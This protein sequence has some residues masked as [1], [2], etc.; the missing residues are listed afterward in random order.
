VKPLFT[1]GIR[2]FA[3]CRT[4]YRVFFLEHSAKQPLPRAALGKVLL[5]VMNWFTECRTLGTKKL[6]AKTCEWQT[7]VKGGARQRAV[8]DRSKADGRQPLSRAEGQHS[9]KMFLCR[10]PD[11]WH[12]AKTSLPSV[13][14]GH[15]A[16]LICIF[17]IL[18]TKLFVVCYY[19]M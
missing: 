4:L 3:E 2:A 12:S 10:V 1:I 9:A 7:L 19:T 18:S 17:L 8:S 6:S 15:S 13:F 11:I 5:S 16:K 14:F